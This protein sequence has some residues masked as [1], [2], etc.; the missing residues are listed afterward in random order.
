MHEIVSLL[1]GI[2]NAK[3][4]FQARFFL[5]LLVD[6]FLTNLA[7]ITLVLFLYINVH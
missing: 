5:T 4:S 3:I 1:P 2:P 6:L 7:D